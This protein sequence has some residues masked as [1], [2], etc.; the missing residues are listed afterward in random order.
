M[1]AK[2]S[3]LL[4]AVL[5]QRCAHNRLSMFFLVR[6]LYAFKAVVCI[7]LGR[8]DAAMKPEQAAHGVARF[9]A[10]R[11]T[12]HPD[13]SVH[14]WS[15]L[16]VGLG[17]FRNWSYDI[18]TDTTPEGEISEDMISRGPINISLGRLKRET[19]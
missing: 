11:V 18:Y 15:E 5:T 9:D 8:F 4:W 17:V 3:T 19:N 6:W 16:A 2:K 7:L 14:H 13:P 12:W 10:E 1:R